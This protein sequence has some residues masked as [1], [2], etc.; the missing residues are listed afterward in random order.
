MTRRAIAAV[1]ATAAAIAGSSVE[2]DALAQACC[3]GASGLTPA[4]LANHERMLVGAQLRFSATHGTYPAHG[5]FYVPTPGRDARFETSVFSSIRLFDR[6]QASVY[7]PLVATRRRSGEQVEGDVALGDLTLLGRYDLVRTGES[8]LPG[9]AVLAGIQAPSGVPSDRGSGLLGADVTGTGAWEGS[10]GV[11]VEKVIRH[12]LLHATVLA[13]VRAPR[14]VVGVEQRLGPRALFLFA[15]GWVWD[16]DAAIL[17]TVSHASEGDAT[18]GGA[19]A[20]GTGF[21]TTQLALLVVTP[22][23]D[24]LRLRTSA[25]TDLP[26]LGE[27][28]AAFGG[29]SISIAKSWY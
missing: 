9:I 1:L 16:D 29:T 18:V 21:R 5:R 11:S 25:F 22:L 3:V 24:T 17:A 8:R 13:G 12:V 10:A 4:W 6:L 27:N 14:D 7:V 28:R 23:S 2:R 15:G 20:D 26:P 19:D